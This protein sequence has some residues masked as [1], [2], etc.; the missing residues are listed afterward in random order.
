MTQYS[1]WPDWLKVMVMGPHA[2]L[3]WFIAVPWFPKSKRQW[4]W[5]GIAV[6]YLAFFFAVMH[7]VFGFMA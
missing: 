7:L 6:A 3:A 4:I 1:L 5:T 2:V